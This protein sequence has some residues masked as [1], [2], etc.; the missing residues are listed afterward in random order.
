M[1]LICYRL[2]SRACDSCTG[3]RC[4]RAPADSLANCFAVVIREL[5]D[6]TL[7]EAIDTV[8]GMLCTQNKECAGIRFGAAVLSV[9]SSLLNL[10]EGFSGRPC[11]YRG[12][13]DGRCLSRV[14]A[15]AEEMGFVSFGWLL[16]VGVCSFGGLVCFVLFIYLFLF[17]L[18]LSLFLFSLAVVGGG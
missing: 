12:L 16:L 1:A 15:W 13:G 17:F 9:D 4:W 2:T 11:L 18:F 7:L 10:S 6:A 14:R 8:L 3:N 5:V